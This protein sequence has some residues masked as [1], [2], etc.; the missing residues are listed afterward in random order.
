MAG[1]W[2]AFDYGYNPDGTL[3]RRDA[4]SNQWSGNKTVQYGYNS[5]KA[6]QSFTVFNQQTTLGPV[7]G[8]RPWRHLHYILEAEPYADAGQRTAAAIES[9]SSEL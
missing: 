4:T 1:S 8:A 7:Q 2:Y 9:E 3:A 6:L 5:V